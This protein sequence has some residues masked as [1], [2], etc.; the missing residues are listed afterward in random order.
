MK[1][2]PKTLTARV[3]SDFLHLGRA[4]VSQE[5]LD[6]MKGAVWTMETHVQGQLFRH[7]LNRFHPTGP[8]FVCMEMDGHRL[9][10]VLFLKDKP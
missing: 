3:A 7:L 9:V 8:R 6:D 2:T 10:R 4:E 1:L 5:D